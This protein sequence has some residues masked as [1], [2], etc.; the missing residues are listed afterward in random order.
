MFTM[1]LIGRLVADPMKQM[2]T[3]NGKQ[4]EVCKFRTAT[5]VWGKPQ[6]V[7]VT[8]WDGLVEPCAKYLYKGRQVSVVGRPSARCT[9]RYD[10]KGQ[11]TQVFEHLCVS[12]EKVEFLGSGR[13]NN[14]D[15]QPEAEEVTA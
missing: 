12:A 7:D 8:V 2:V 9:Y 4:K 15:E 1:S 6:F 3:S 5:T 10:D 13:G 11:I 14:N